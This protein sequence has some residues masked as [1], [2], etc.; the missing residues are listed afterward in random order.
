MATLLP[1]SGSDGCTSCTA[2]DLRRSLQEDYF[3]NMTDTEQEPAASHAATALSA[4]TIELAREKQYTVVDREPPKLRIHDLDEVVVPRYSSRVD[5]AKVFQVVSKLRTAPHVSVWRRHSDFKLLASRISEQ[6]TVAQLP[7]SLPAL[8]PIS[9]VEQI[10]QACR[11]L[12]NTEMK[13]RFVN[14]RPNSEPPPT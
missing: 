14:V 2:F 3:T 7:V 13:E 11:P 5:G 10:D 12:T 8:E 4:S 1:A 9:V 6:L